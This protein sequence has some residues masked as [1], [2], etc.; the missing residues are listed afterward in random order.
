M[1]VVGWNRVVNWVCGV[2]FL[3]GYEIE[4]LRWVLESTL[5]MAERQMCEHIEWFIFLDLV[6]YRIT[7]AST[8]SV[9][10]SWLT[11]VYSPS[12]ADNLRVGVY[13]HRE[14]PWAL[15]YHFC[16]RLTFRPTRCRRFSPWPR[17]CHFPA[18]D[19]HH[20]PQ[21][22]VCHRHWRCCQA[23]WQPIQSLS[24]AHPPPPHQ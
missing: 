21:H 17:Q 2:V 24:P 1:G 15:V 7:Y 3:E 12:L 8:E 14:L 13:Q 16:G 23:Y 19:C 6:M 4:G 5:T 18:L 11:C 22:P 20:L 10:E 9:S